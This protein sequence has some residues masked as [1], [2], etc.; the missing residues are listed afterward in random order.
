MRTAEEMELREAGEAIT[1]ALRGKTFGAV[2]IDSVDVDVRAD[3]FGDPAVFVV[4]KSSSPREMRRTR[5]GALRPQWA[6]DDRSAAVT[7]FADAVSR[8]D[9]EVNAY[10]S[11]LPHEDSLVAPAS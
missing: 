4:A 5:R 10:F 1:A 8:L 3:A 2:T 9:H 7:A 11:L 6:K